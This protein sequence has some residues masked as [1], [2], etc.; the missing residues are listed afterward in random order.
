MHYEGLRSYLDYA[1]IAYI[2]SKL[3]GSSLTLS[4]FQ[5]VGQFV[6]VDASLDA[7]IRNLVLWL[8]SPAIRKTRVSILVY[9]ASSTGK[10]FL[11]EQ[12]FSAVG[13]KDVFKDRRIVCSP[14]VNVQEELKNTFDRIAAVP[15]DGSPPFLFIDEIDVEFPT[16]IYPSLLTLLDKGEIGGA[17]VNSEAFVLFWAGGKHESV[18]AFKSFLAKKQKSPKFEKGL[19]MFNR[20]KHRIDLPASLIRDKN[21][22]LLLG[23]AAL[24]KRFTPPIKVDRSIVRYLRNM[25]MAEK[26]GVREF[27]IFSNRVKDESGVLCLPDE[28]CQGHEI[29]VTS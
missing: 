3:H 13:Q 26:S 7:D 5:P 25:P 9:G 18:G 23:L 11:V 27:E 29:T 17:R 19:D 24:V 16:S 20:A 10:S 2:E 15:P 1:E 14:S 28:E 8:N 4:E 6:C 12:L 21:Q 22:K